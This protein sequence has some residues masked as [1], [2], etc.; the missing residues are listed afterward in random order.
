MRQIP[1]R[2]MPHKNLHYRNPQTGS[3][4]RI[5]GAPVAPARAQVVLRTKQVRNAAGETDVSS[6]QVTMD[7]VQVERDVDGEVVAEHVV[8]LGARFTICKGTPRQRT[9]KVIALDVY[10]DPGVQPFIVAYLE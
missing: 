4:G 6:A 1:S 10:D 9:A 2:L 5:F 7:A 8:E 3:N